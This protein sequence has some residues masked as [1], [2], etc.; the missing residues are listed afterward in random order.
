MHV[1][2]KK[3]RVISLCVLKW[4]YL[5]KHILISFFNEIILIKAFKFEFRHA[6]IFDSMPF[7][8]SVNLIKAIH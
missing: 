8:S 4:R 1:Q 3:D 5:L 2:D 6:K 7:A